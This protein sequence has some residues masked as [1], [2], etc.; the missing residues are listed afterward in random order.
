MSDK[1][2]EEKIEGYVCLIKM[3]EESDLDEWEAINAEGDLQDAI[4][5]FCKQFGDRGFDIKA[6]VFARSFEMN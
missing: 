3:I 2:I 6:E 1:E 5:D 4:N